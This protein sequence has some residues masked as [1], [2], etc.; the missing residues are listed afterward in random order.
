M[1]YFSGNP[2]DLKGYWSSLYA[3]LMKV[4]ECEECNEQ[5]KKREAFEIMEAIASTMDALPRW[6]GCILTSLLVL[7]YIAGG[8]AGASMI[9]KTVRGAFL[10]NFR[11][12][13]TAV[14]VNTACFSITNVAQW[15]GPFR[16]QAVMIISR[17]QPDIS[18]ATNPIIDLWWG[19]KGLTRPFSAKPIWEP[20]EEWAGGKDRIGKKSGPVDAGY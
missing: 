9:T 16:H 19:R 3:R 20:Y 13:R 1:S 11:V 15:W 12:T 7:Q 8:V 17:C 4:P 14:T 6:S 18:D 10:F 2:K 5:T